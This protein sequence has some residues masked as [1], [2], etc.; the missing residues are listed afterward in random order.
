MSLRLRRPLAPPQSEQQTDAGGSPE[1]DEPQPIDT[2]NVLV[3]SGIHRGRFPIGGLPVRQARRV[4]RQLIT[5]DDEAVAVIGGRVVDEDEVI[6]DQVTHLAFV[7]P[8]AIKGAA[9]PTPGFPSP[10]ASDRTAASRS[11]SS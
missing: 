11:R 5:I 1:Q 4:L 6:S 9:G 3:T 10:H 8:S 7:K 2:A